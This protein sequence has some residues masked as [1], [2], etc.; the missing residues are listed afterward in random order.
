MKTTKNLLVYL[1]IMVNPVSS[2]MAG[3]EDLDS[4]FLTDSVRS[5]HIA[6]APVFDSLI[7]GKPNVVISLDSSA[8]MLLPAYSIESFDPDNGDGRIGYFVSEAQYRYDAQEKLFVIDPSLKRGDELAWDGQFLNWLTMKRCDL[9]KLLLIGENVTKIDESGDQKTRA[10]QGCQA[11]AHSVVTIEFKSSSQYSPISDYQQITIENGYFQTGLAPS[12]RFNIRLLSPS[13]R[14]GLLDE[15]SAKVNWLFL[16]KGGRVLSSLDIIKSNIENTSFTGDRKQA[17]ADQFQ[18]YQNRVMTGDI[19]FNESEQPYFDKVQGVELPCKR[20]SFLYV[21]SSFNS[22]GNNTLPDIDCKPNLSGDQ[23]IHR[24][25]VI[26]D[27]S[28]GMAADNTVGA[29]YWPHQVNDLISALVI[30]SDEKALNENQRI[31]SGT[32]LGKGMFLQSSYMHVK[33]QENERLTWVGE[34][35]ALMMDSTGRKRHDDGDGVIETTNIDPI[36]DTCFDQLEKVIRVKLSYHEDKR[37]SARD[38]EMCSNLV[39]KYFYEDLRYL[40]RA[41]EILSKVSDSDV[42]KQREFESPDITRRYINTNI[43]GQE[44]D[45]LAASFQPSHVG[46]LNTR[47]PDEAQRIIEFVRG[48]DQLGMRSRKLGG[49]VN[50]LGDFIHS[51]PVVVGAPAENLH[52]LQDDKSYLDFFRQYQN[53]RR[54]VYIGGNDGLLHS[55]NAGWFDEEEQKHVTYMPGRSDWQLGQE[56]WGFVPMNVLPHLKYLT[57]EHYGASVS[58]HIYLLDQTPYIV[59]VKIFGRGGVSGQNDRTYYNTKGEKISDEAH[60]NGWGTILVVGLGLGGSESQLYLNP[61]ID[62][63]DQ[64]ENVL[65]IRPSYLIFDITDSEQAPKLLTEFTHEKLS[66]SFSMPTVVTKKNKSEGLRWYMA[67]GSGPSTQIAGGVRTLVDQNAHLFMLDLHTMQLSKHFAQQGVLDLNESNAFVGGLASADYDLDAETDA[68]YFGT[69]SLQDDQTGLPEWGG[70]LHRL[71]N[72]G[73]RTPNW[74]KEVLFDAQS[75]VIH[76]PSLSI[77]KSQNRWIHFGTGVLLNHNDLLSQSQNY[78]FG[79]KEPRNTEGTFA[80]EGGISTAS[81][82]VSFSQLM[83]V[84]DIRLNGFSYRQANM[85]APSSFSNDG[86]K[87]LDRL[88]QSFEDKNNYQAGWFKRLS[89]GESVSDRGGVLGG[90]YFQ[91]TFQ[92]VRDYCSFDGDSIHYM[93]NHTTGTPLSNADFRSPTNNAGSAFKEV[94]KSK[95]PVQSVLY[96]GERRNNGVVNILNPHSDGSDQQDNLELNGVFSKEISWRVLRK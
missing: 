22:V 55:F 65:S 31:V 39:Y 74:G 18:K 28:G 9:A 17:F 26:S 37:P 19:P 56:I 36:V 59:D 68:V 5:R 8:E 42:S 50:K 64:S 52:L 83:D 54:V 84:T 57:R 3:T 30:S 38:V 32:T 93:L 48:K 13:K 92:P 43:L 20:V 91:N 95:S 4:T 41:G 77:D 2:L 82:S 81:R 47:D 79:I 15:L 85:L 63:G 72:L 58:D 46:L 27:M 1:L 76:S 71:R 62:D 53:R 66:S 87:E 25:H 90:V 6:H 24:Y 80:M 69:A 10:I 89:P 49:Q 23:S 34:L 12:Q 67:F 86:I 33:S 94:V 40:W 78:L 11:R 21:S 75:P 96:L 16:A 51:K 70:K 7:A 88:L 73:R 45:F 60:P 14:P 61:D 29:V 35:D 44:T